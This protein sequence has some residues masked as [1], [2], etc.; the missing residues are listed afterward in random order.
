[1]RRYFG[2]DRFGPS[3]SLLAGEIYNLFKSPLTPEEKDR[4]LRSML[5][6]NKKVNQKNLLSDLHALGI[7]KHSTDM[8]EIEA[9]LNDTLPK[10]DSMEHT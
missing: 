9:V 5:Q 1:M 7:K 6:S 10:H 2:F 8:F 4:H 3:T